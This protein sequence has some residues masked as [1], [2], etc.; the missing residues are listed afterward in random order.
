MSIS[1]HNL[2]T[3]SLLKCQAVGRGRV[4]GQARNR[5]GEQKLLRF[6][7]HVF[8]GAQASLRVGRGIWNGGEE[9]SKELQCLEPRA[10]E[11]CQG[12][13]PPALEGNSDER[14]PKRSSERNGVALVFELERGV[15][16]P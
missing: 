8:R 9:E 3:H 5:V 1:T 7:A 2:G 16:G 10:Q 13:E 14:G 15:G 11:G 12:A 6:S 4:A